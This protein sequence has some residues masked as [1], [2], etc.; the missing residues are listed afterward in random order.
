MKEIEY[1]IEFS[2]PIRV[3]NLCG[4]EIP[5]E[6]PYVEVAAVDDKL[7]LY[8]HE[9]CRKLVLIYADALRMLHAEP[10]EELAK[11]LWLDYPEENKL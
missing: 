6:C 5:P 3:C 7:P 2:V 11:S 4:R 1:D 10:T 8:F 9:N